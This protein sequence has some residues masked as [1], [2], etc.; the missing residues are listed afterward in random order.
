MLFRS[1]ILHILRENFEIEEGDNP[2]Q[3]REKLRQGLHRLDPHL[4]WLLP[5]LEALFAL[6]GADDGLKHLDPK[7]KREQIF[8]ALYTLSTCA[9]RHRPQMLVHENLHWIDRTSEDCLARLIER[10]EDFPILVLTT[11][12]PGYNVPWANKTY[13]TQIALDDLTEVEAETMVT[14]L[15]GSRSLPTGLMPLIREK[16]G[17]NPAFIEEVLHALLE[18]GL[19]E[20]RLDALQWT[21]AT[22]VAFPDTIQDLARARID[23]LEEPVKRTL[24]TAAVIG[25]AFS[26]RLLNRL[27]E[28]PVQSHV[29][30]LKQ[31]GLIYEAHFFPELAYR[32]KHAVIQDVAYQGMLVQRRQERHGAIGQAIEILYADHLEEQV[33]ILAY[34]YAL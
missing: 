33:A 9:S 25:R 20:R 23:Q 15:L 12:Q 31:L 6:P 13:Y 8:D 34:H 27:C 17:G 21:S 1:P 26:F 19:L 2:L 14:T 24:Q 5:F 18:R 30:T 29:E 16:S 32:F 10:L 3:I 7:D 11:H 4:A 28:G 22:E